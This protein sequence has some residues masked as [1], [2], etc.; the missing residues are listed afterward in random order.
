MA[1][2]LVILHQ[3][4]VVWR[5]TKENQPNQKLTSRSQLVQV[6]KNPKIDI[7]IRKDEKYCMFQ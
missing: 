4:N 1:P 2:M 5:V 7:V 6:Q 3:G